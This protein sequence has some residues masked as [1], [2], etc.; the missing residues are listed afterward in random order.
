MFDRVLNSSVY[1]T[2]HW[3][4][5]RE[6]ETLLQNKFRFCHKAQGNVSHRN[7]N[8]VTLLRCLTIAVFVLMIGIQGRQQLTCEHLVTS[9]RL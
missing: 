1:T 5:L 6:L 2:E 3:K 8:D 9:K 7:F 4:E